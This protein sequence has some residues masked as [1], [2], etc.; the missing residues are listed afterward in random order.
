MVC[1]GDDG[2]DEAHIESKYADEFGGDH[3]R[4]SYDE[5]IHCVNH[6]CGL[7]D[8]R[9]VNADLCFLGMGPK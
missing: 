8:P 4:C 3:A 7:D 1:A 9:S 6:L 5:A 2:L